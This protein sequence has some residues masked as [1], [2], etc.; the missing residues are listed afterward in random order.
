MLGCKLLNYCVLPEYSYFFNQ[1]YRFF[2]LGNCSWPLPKAIIKLKTPLFWF[3]S[4]G[5]VITKW[6]ERKQNVILIEFGFQFH[7]LVWLFQR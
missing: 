4:C 6:R 1:S 5:K 2:S 7:Y 3:Q